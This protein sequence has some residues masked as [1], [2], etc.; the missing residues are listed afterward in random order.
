MTRRLKNAAAPQQP[1]RGP[2]GR[3]LIAGSQSRGTRGPAAGHSCFPS[4]S[5]NRTLAMVVGAWASMER[6]TSFRMSSSLAPSAII[7]SA[8][9]SAARSDSARFKSSMSV[10]VPHH[11][12][13][14]L[15]SSRSGSTWNRNHR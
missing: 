2:I 4:E 7:S 3:G 9:F 11:W 6:H 14:R 15:V 10:A 8:R 12:T 1:S 13:T 5:I